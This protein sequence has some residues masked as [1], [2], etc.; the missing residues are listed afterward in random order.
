MDSDDKPRPHTPS[1]TPDITVFPRNGPLGNNSEIRPPFFHTASIA[2]RWVHSFS[3]T[4]R[5]FTQRA[6]TTHTH[7]H[8]HKL[9]P[10]FTFY[11]L[12]LRFALTLSPSRKGFI[13]NNSPFPSSLPVPFV[14]IAVTFCLRCHRPTVLRSMNSLVPPK[15]YSLAVRVNSNSSNRLKCLGHLAVM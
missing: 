9:Q 7:T 14:S 1:N 12:S 3:M 8:T 4:L 6:R 10:I 15:Y 5:F 11:L 2:A 13:Y